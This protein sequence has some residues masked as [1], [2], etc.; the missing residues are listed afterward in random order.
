MDPARAG[1]MSILN[2]AVYNWGTCR[3]CLNHWANDRLIQTFVL[4]PAQGP[5]GY[6]VC[7]TWKMLLRRVF[8][9]CTR[10][11]ALSST[12]VNGNRSNWTTKTL[13]TTSVQAEITTLRC[14][15]RSLQQSANNMMKLVGLQHIH[16]ET[17]TAHTCL[18]DRR[19]TDHVQACLG[20]AKCR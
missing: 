19:F 2:V 3:N 14:D 18:F 12:L 1:C 10:A 8:C 5:Q 4:L 9:Q 20:I 17:C 15:I 11:K 16:S 13:N 6:T 7:Y